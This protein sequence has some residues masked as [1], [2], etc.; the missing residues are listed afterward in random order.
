MSK[1]VVF[2]LFT[3]YIC[4]NAEAYVF[5]TASVGVDD[6]LSSGSGMVDSC[7]GRLGRSVSRCRCS[8]SLGVGP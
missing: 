4:A 7:Q 6:F 3:A 5:W 8:A 1:L 2:Y